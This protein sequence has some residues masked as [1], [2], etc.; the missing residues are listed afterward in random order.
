MAHII[1][2]TWD[3][4]KAREAEFSGHRLRLIVDPDDSDA[5]YLAPPI[6]VRDREHLV[7]LLV[8]AANSPVHEVTQATWDE[9]HQWLERRFGSSG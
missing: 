1:E 4:I 9:R 3:E 6:E 7:Q 8:E 2:G 5:E